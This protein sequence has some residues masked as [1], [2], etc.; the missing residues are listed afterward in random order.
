MG[1]ILGRN[2]G[3][4]VGAGS[5]ILDLVLAIVVLVSHQPITPEL[6]AVA[7]AAHGVLVA[8]VGLIANA[9]DPTTVPTFALTTSAASSSSSNPNPSGGTSSGTTASLPSGPSG[10]DLTLPTPVPSA[11]DPAAAASS[12]DTPPAQ[13]GDPGAAGPAGP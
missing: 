3:L 11:V 10:G 12:S 9:S 5:A 6:G 4:W 2:A 1:T 7:L 8:I 13:A